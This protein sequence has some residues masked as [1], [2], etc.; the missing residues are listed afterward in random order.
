MV[1]QDQVSAKERLAPVSKF[2]ILLR[3]IKS[4]LHQTNQ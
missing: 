1:M 4:W 3:R 2:K